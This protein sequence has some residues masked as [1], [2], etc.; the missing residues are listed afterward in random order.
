MGNSVVVPGCAVVDPR[1]PP[2]L[3]LFA[4]MV[5][6]ALEADVTLAMASRIILAYET[7]SK[8]SECVDGKNMPFGSNRM[9]SS[10]PFIF[11][12]PRRSF[13][14]PA[15][16]TSKLIQYLTKLGFFTSELSTY[17]RP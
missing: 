4:T 12:E 13:C 14:K 10:A 9:F 17:C 7:L 8:Y 3:F 16:V 15:P 11:E 1:C 5:G 2:V 6:H